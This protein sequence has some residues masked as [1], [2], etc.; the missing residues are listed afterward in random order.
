MEHKNFS[1][2]RKTKWAHSYT[3]LIV[4][5]CETRRKNFGEHQTE[6]GHIVYYSRE[7]DKHMHGVGFLINKTIKNAIVRCCPISCRLI[8]IQ[9]RAAP[10]TSLWY[11]YIHQPSAHDDNKVEEFYHLLQANI[12]RVDNKDILII[13]GDWNAKVG[14]NALIT[15]STLCGPSCNAISNEQ[16]LCLLDFAIY[17]NLV[18]ANTLGIH[19]PLHRWTWHEPN[20]AHHNQIDYI[21]VQN[22]FQSGI[23]RTKTRTLPGA[24][25][26][27][28][29]DL[30]LLN[31]KVR[32]KKTNMP[33]KIR[34]KYNLDRLK[35]PAIVDTFQAVIGWK[36][37]VGTTTSNSWWGCWNINHQ[38]QH[39]HD[40]SNGRGTRQVPL[41]SAILNQRRDPWHVRHMKKTEGSQEHNWSRGI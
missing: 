8:S 31:F 33:K 29:H 1:P 21:S 13:Q 11:K 25:I 36:F 30:D 28:D 14:T 9:L 39:S 16:G 34:L 18:L 23:N 3:W 15:W 32:L 17:K 20:G 35:V 38:F 27:S 19:K 5:L 22:R 40:E 41:Q 26:S 6:D 37:A 10:S 12:D 4:G 24:E 7:S 2:S